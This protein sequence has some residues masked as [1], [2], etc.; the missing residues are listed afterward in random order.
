[1]SSRLATLNSAGIQR[2]R[3]R[4]ATAPTVLA[5][6]GLVVVGGL[7]EPLAVALLGLPALARPGGPRRRRGAPADRARPP[8]RLPAEPHRAPG[9]AR[10]RRGDRRR[11]ESR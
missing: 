10:P 3:G 9:Q 2:I 5:G 4:Y 8:R 1:M 6:G 7:V 11:R